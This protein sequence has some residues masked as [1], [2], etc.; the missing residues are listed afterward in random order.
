M[1]KRHKDNEVEPAEPNLQL[2]KKISDYMSPALQS[3]IKISFKHKDSNISGNN[4]SINNFQG[5]NYLTVTQ[6]KV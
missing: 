2:K 4:Y 1:R 3:S 5:N 6:L